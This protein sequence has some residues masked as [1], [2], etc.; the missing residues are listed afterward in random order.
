MK[1]KLLTPKL[2]VGIY[3][4]DEEFL[5]H[6]IN[7]E[8]KDIIKEDIEISL[9]EVDMNIAPTVYQILVSA[10]E[11]F[12]SIAEI[13][14]VEEELKSVNLGKNMTAFDFLKSSRDRIEDTDFDSYTNEELQDLYTLFSKVN[15][16]LDTAPR[17]RS[18][19]NNKD[20]YKA[21]KEVSSKCKEAVVSL[22]DEFPDI[23][24]ILSNDIE[25]D[26]KRLVDNKPLFVGTK[27]NHTEYNGIGQLY[28][29]S[30]KTLIHLFRYQLRLRGVNVK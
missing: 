1:C 11:K 16:L 17:S 2:I 23:V 10:K 7:R 21:L 29:E 4:Y 27:I 19:I 13:Y 18:L 12:N 15:S 22:G 8:T 6:I 28:K 30:T 26:I 3:L 25:K 9:Q 5:Y 24:D 20:F 14:F